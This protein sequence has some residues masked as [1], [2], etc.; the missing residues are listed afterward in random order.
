MASS[1]RR[2]TVGEMGEI[3]VRGPGVVTGQDWLRTGDLGTFDEDG[4]LHLVGRA[5]RMIN[6]AGE[7]V[8]PPSV[9][10][11]LRGLECVSDAL[12]VG[13]P[14]SRWGQVVAALIVLSPAGRDRASSVSVEYLGEAL[15]GVL[16]PW[17]RVRRVLVVDELPVTTTGKPDPV[18]GAALFG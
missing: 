1:T 12:V 2:A 9:E 10:R 7:L 6:T 4:W 14:H 11:A 17:E 15:A 18:A 3:W 5:H 8:A 13:V 16:A